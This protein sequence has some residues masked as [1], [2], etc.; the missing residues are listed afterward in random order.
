MEYL[1]L[2]GYFKESHSP[3]RKSL[4][5]HLRWISILKNNCTLSRCF[6]KFR[7]ITVKAP[8]NQI[9]CLIM[10]KILWLVVT[11]I[12]LVMLVHCGEASPSKYVWHWI[13][14][15]DGV[16]LT[17]SVGKVVVHVCKAKSSAETWFFCLMQL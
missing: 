15:K 9:P 7:I 11:T 4:S 14:W 16:L 2:M 5:V 17:F 3:I 12:P 10:Y 1:S 13:E 6:H 8:A